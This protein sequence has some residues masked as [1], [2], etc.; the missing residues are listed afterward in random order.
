M[1]TY[2][3]YDQK[4]LQ[5]SN[6][7]YARALWRTG[8][9]PGMRVLHGF[10]LSMFAAGVPMVNAMTYMGACAIPVGAEA[11]TERMLTQ[12]RLTRPQ[13]L[14]CTPSYAEYLIE[15]APQMIERDVG[16]LGIRILIVGGESGGAI[17]E[18]RDK[19]MSA[20]GA[21]L[22]D[23]Q[24][25]AMSCDLNVGFHM[26]SLGGSYFELLDPD[27]KEPRPIEDGAEGEWVSTSLN[28]AEGVAPT[29]RFAM[30]DIYRIHTSP[31]A[32]GA[33]GWRYQIIGRVDDM[34]KVKGVM[35]YPAAIT[36]LIN[37]FAPRVTGFYRIVLDEPPPRVV[38]PI[39]LRVEYGE[40]VN[41]EDLQALDSE[42]CEKMH[43]VLKIRPVIEWLPANT[44]DRSVH[45]TQ[46]FERRYD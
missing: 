25:P 45:K 1:P 34:L 4:G 30:G 11:G 36:S 29:L 20:Y 38:P 15:R 19:L 6:E 10:A 13:V 43:A 17:P 27:T 16:T 39:K 21:K 41:P 2:Y 22:Y 42:V 40:H 44:L 46:V 14:T 3:L 8:V 37:G 9:R 18:V 35:V 5:A 24:G 23:M 32:C 28:A 31:C 12:A 7:V 26:V 33:T